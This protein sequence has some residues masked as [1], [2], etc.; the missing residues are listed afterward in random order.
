MYHNIDIE[1]FYSDLEKEPSQMLINLVEKLIET[2][3]YSNIND[4]ALE[5]KKIY[6][7]NYNFY[8]QLDN[9]YVQKYNIFGL[10]DQ[11]TRSGFMTTA[12]HNRKLNFD[13]HVDITNVSNI[14]AGVMRHIWCYFRLND[15][16]GKIYKN[17]H[18]DDINPVD[19]AEYYETYSKFLP[20][21][22]KFM[23][24]D[25]K[26][27]AFYFE[28]GCFNITKCV[29]TEHIVTFEFGDYIKPTSQ[30]VAMIFSKTVPQKQSSTKQS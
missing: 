28:G 7:H 9:K 10:G 6:K 4:V 3:T 8:C 21:F 16:D 18:L 22:K 5:I 14:N 17:D 19:F 12:D 27:L 13:G 1:E 2:N 26:N 29:E 23:K 20:H 25:Y 11:A 24:Y 15:A 30:T